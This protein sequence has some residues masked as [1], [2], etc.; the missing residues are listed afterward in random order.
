MVGPSLDKLDVHTY[1]AEHK[2]VGARIS[3]SIT[4]DVRAMSDFGSTA[5]IIQQYRV[6]TKISEGGM[7]EVYLAQD[8]KLGR[9]VALKILPHEVISGV[10]VESL[11]L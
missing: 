11:S 7:G 8:T 6:L 5:R 3:T 1:A 4:P 2:E 9:K 10:D